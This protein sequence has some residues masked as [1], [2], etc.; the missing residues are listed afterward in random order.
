M[1]VPVISGFKSGHV[2]PFITVPIGAKAKIDTYKGEI[3]ID[4]AVK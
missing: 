4:K 3:I 2:R 1:K